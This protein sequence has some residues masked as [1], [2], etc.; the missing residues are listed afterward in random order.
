MGLLRRSPA[1]HRTQ[2]GAS[3]APCNDIQWTHEE[4]IPPYL[5]FFSRGLSKR[6]NA[7]CGNGHIRP[8]GYARSNAN[9]IYDNARVNRHTCADANA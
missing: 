9:S 6:G 2:C 4:N 7:S 1:L 8:I 5:H 3:V